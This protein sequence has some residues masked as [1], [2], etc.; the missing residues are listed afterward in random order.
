MF[1]TVLIANRGE[2][3]CRIIRSVHAAG[4]RAV[5]VYS[6]ADAGA[7]HVRLADAAVRLGPA[8]AAE[9]YLDIQKVLDAA[10]ATGAGAIH[11]GYG[12]L[13]EN[14]EF[15]RACEDA[16]IVFIGPSADAIQV[17]GDKISAKRAVAARD[18]PTVPGIAAHG[19]GDDELAAAVPGIGYPILIKPSAGGGGKGMHV[20][21]EGDDLRASLAAARREAAGSFGDD[22]IFIE[23]FIAN[24]RHIEVQVLADA[25]GHV[26]HLGERECSLQRRHQKVIEE[27]PSP[28]LDAATRARIG[29][30]ACETAR[31]VDYRGAGTVEFIVSADAPDEFFFM[32]MNTRL[33]VEHAVTEQVT[34][35]DLVAEQLRIAAGEAI[36][37]AQDEIV[38]DGHSFEVRIYA[39]D[40][41]AGFLPTGGR[42]TGVVEPSGDGVRVD[43]SLEPGLDVSISYDPMLAKIVTWGADREQARQR[44]LRALSH[45]A[46]F[47]FTTNIEF[48]ARLL[49]LPDVAAGRMDTGLIARELDA[50][51]FAEATEREAVEAA[52]LFAHAAQARGSSPW[53]RLGG[54]RIGPHAPAHLRLRAHDG[55]VF[56]VH[57]RGTPEDARVSVGEGDPKPA[58]VEVH[59]DMATVVWDG[60]GRTFPAHIAPAEVSLVSRAATFVFAREALA[61]L[62]GDDEGAPQ[63]LSPMPGSVILA[64]VST[65]DQV[66]PGDPIVV[67]EAMKMEHV[68]RAG[69]AGTVALQVAEG[70]QVSR[71]QLLAE[72]STGTEEDV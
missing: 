34:G 31:S 37:R 9:S 3:A 36:S 42:V 20:V 25:H 15:A 59:D 22:T 4:L 71:G 23:R 43:T 6:D 68:V 52:L 63:V 53:D 46:V 48:G 18:V 30:A 39:E 10:R 28:L 54:W 72:I 49:E 60:V 32:E 58:R 65:G 57:V 45:T 55:D 8:A 40:A 16:G 12:F 69:I 50:I 44:M 70:D 26:I 11:P 14:A 61:R 21:E 66:E 29:E 24:P 1:D 19:L 2:I 5:A 67:V 33:Q 38:H 17:M 41:R 64:H 51:E 27:A 47:G 13:A 62:A 7:R 56:D 35:V